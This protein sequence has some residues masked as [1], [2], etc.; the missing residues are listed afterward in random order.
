ML[1]HD[2]T[3]LASSQQLSL[4]CCQ[5]FS[6]LCVFCTEYGSLAWCGLS[7]TSSH[8]LES[9]QLKAL[10]IAGCSPSR[11]QPVYTRHSAHLIRLFCRLLSDDVPSHQLLLG[12]PR[13]LVQRVF[14]FTPSIAVYS[15]ASSKD[16]NASL[17]SPAP[18]S[19][20]IYLFSPLSFF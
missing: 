17:F 14:P 7:A 2:C 16:T 12:D 13:P 15:P 11:L 1:Y 20:S 8:R 19:I 3:S 5:F 6:C 10:A 4:L 9:I 18:G